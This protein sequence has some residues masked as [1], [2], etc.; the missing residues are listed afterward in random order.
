MDTELPDRSGSAGFLIP[1][2]KDNK[3]RDENLKLLNGN[4]GD[5]AD[6]V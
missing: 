6:K 2:T 4:S 1:L 3:T 5:L